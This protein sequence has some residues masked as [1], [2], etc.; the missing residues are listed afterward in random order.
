MQQA[1]CSS[2]QPQV[3]HTV[4]WHDWARSAFSS[5]VLFDS[6]VCILVCF[7]SFISK[8]IVQGFWDALRIAHS[9][10]VVL[11]C[12]SVAVFNW[13][14][15]APGLVVSVSPFP[16]ALFCSLFLQQGSGCWAARSSAAVRVCS[17]AC[18]LPGALS[19]SEGKLRSVLKTVF[20]LEWF[21]Y[22][23]NS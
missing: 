1:S 17:S 18:W 11:Y 13:M 3:K 16:L 10:C 6:R 23:A 20:V 12:S 8:R 22:L 5:D 14:T 9:A 15:P 2:C 19:L 7:G 21:I 4:R